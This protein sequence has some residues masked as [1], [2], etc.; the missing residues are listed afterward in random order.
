[1][2]TIKINSIGLFVLVAILFTGCMDNFLERDPFGTI[3]EKTFFT[4]SDHANLAAI[5]CY[6]K[7]QHVNA[8]WADAQLELG[9]TGDFSSS[10]LKDAQAFYAGSF[11]PNESNVVK[12][13]WQ[14]AYQGIA[15]CNTNIEGVTNMSETIIDAASRNKYLAEMRFIRAFWYFRLI[16]FYGDVPLRTT[17]V[18]DP[19]DDSQ[20]KLAATPKEQIISELILPDLKFAAQYLPASW[21]NAFHNRATIGAAYAYL[22]EVYLYQ[23]DYEN[24]ILAGKEV[25]KSGFSLI[26]NPGNVLRVDY[27][28]CPEIIFSVGLGVGL[29]SYREYYYGTIETLGADGRIMRGDTYSGDYFYPSHEF[30][31]FFQTID[32]KSITEGSPYYSSAEKWKNRDPRFDAT[33]FTVMD[34]IETTKGKVMQWDPKW[35]VNTATGFDIQKRGVWYGADTWN[36]QVDYHFMRLSRVYLHIAEAYALKSS[37]DFGK[38]AEYVEKVRSRARNFALANRNK[39]V[40]SGLTDDQVLPAFR[41]ASAADA[42]KAIDYE[43]RVEFFTE[44]C[45]RYF[46]LKRWNTLKVEWPRVGGFTW[47]DKLYNLPIPADEL[48]ANDQLRQNHTGWGS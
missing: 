37:P 7:L 8:H 23:K 2:K 21:D 10:G 27:E 16:Q 41:I 11:N 5:A 35:L 12:G 45:I 28:A 40:P 13:I 47:D 9:M 20:V 34:T 19:T 26:D 3:N 4:K 31:N 36:R 46:D 30:V 44:D 1:M 6:A 39:F 29:E 24:A 43:S 15:V 48:N 17:S 25:E 42:M 18:S 14:K 22:C 32:G 33:F 38:C